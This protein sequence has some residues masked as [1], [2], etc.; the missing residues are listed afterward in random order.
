ML[1]NHDGHESGCPVSDDPDEVLEVGEEASG[2]TYG[3]GNDDCCDDDGEKVAWNPDQPRY[4]ELEVQCDAVPEGG[5]QSWSV[6]ASTHLSLRTSDDLHCR[7]D[8]S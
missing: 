8:V 2:S 5:E 6:S 7:G 3:D 4:E 1:D